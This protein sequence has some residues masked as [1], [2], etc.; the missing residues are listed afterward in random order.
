VISDPSPSVVNY[1][2]ES[3]LKEAS[4]SSDSDSDVDF[5]ADPVLLEDRQFGYHVAG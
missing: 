3:E 5:H 2:P 4:D 1:L